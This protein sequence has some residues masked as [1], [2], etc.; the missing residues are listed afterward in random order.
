MEKIDPTVFVD[1]Y[2]KIFP[3]KKF[4]QRMN[5]KKHLMKIIP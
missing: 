3:E 5:L 4:F 2:G 1:S